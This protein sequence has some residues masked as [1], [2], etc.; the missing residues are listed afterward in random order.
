MGTLERVGPPRDGE[1]VLA[2]E[3]LALGLAAG[4]ARLPG[5]D[6]IAVGAGELLGGK[7]DRDR[8]RFRHHVV[9]LR[10][11]PGIF[12]LA[13]RRVAPRAAVAVVAGL[14]YGLRRPAHPRLLIALAGRCRAAV[15]R[16]GI[17]AIGIV[18]RPLGAPDDVRRQRVRG[19]AARCVE[20]GLVQ[21]ER[22]GRLEE[23]ERVLDLPDQ[24]GGKAGADRK[25]CSDGKAG[26]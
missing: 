19:I 12:A 26:E 15:R 8:V 1:L 9:F 16:R 6:A 3:L 23:P 14:A 21:R 11:A 24:I 20:G 7:P 10:R 18:E 13:D 2:G 17:L 22:L 25:A 5:P 4:L